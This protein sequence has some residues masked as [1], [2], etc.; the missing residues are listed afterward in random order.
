[1]QKYKFIDLFSG[2]GGLLIGFQ[3][4]GFE[5]VQSIDN[6][7]PARETHEFNHSRVPFKKEDIREINFKDYQNVDVII[8][9]PPC[10]GF[11]SIGKQYEADIRN[12]LILNFARAVETVKPNFFLMENVRGINNKKYDNLILEFYK[13]LNK[14]G[15]KNIIREV[16]CAANFGV[17]Q[18]RYRTF[19]MGSLNNKELHF[20]K[21][22]ISDKKKF[23]TVKE[24]IQ[25]LE[26]KENLVDNHV[27]MKHNKIVEKRI[28]Y[29]KEGGGINPNIPPELLKGSRTDFKNNNLKNYSHI[30]KRLSYSLPSTTMVP[31]H[32]A[33]PLHPRLNRSL[34]V[35]EAARL[36]TFPDTVKF[37]GTRQEQCILVGNAVPVKLA[38]ALAKTIKGYLDNQ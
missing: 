24:A 32:N 29:I 8:G 18:L 23:K 36:Q 37:F 1:M 27:P 35:R 31:G 4:A 26:G 28:S 34:T 30:Y 16:L 33:F 11:S 5:C 3:N 20:P 7:E 38:E 10:Q 17:P 15:Y 19:F 13:I 2:A 25:D 21:E 9:G 12:N 14:A 22:T 6:W